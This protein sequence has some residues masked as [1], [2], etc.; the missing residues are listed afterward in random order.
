MGWGKG[1]GV[2]GPEK[3]TWDRVTGWDYKRVDRGRARDTGR[4]CVWPRRRGPGEGGVGLGG[5][6][7]SQP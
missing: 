3:G 6:G 4:A 5:Q 7:S 1:H 2:G